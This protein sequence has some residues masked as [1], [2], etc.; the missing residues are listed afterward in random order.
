LV[1][2]LSL[3]DKLSGQFLSLICNESLTCQGLNL[4]PGHFGLFYPY[5]CSHGKSYLLVSWSAGDRCDMAG[6]GDLVQRTGDGRIGGV[7][8]CRTIGRS[9]DVVCALYHQQG[10][11]ECGFLG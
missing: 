7:L 3:C 9:G 1:T 11:E 5:L 6:V 4:N 2:A 8:S 10:D